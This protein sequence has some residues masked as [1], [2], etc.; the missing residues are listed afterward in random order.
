[1]FKTAEEEYKWAQTQ[2]KDCSKCKKSL[3][4]T[5]YKFNT[6]G[7][8]PFDRHG[9]RLLRPECGTCGKKV[10]AGKNKAI[11][12]A[13]E[14]GIPHKAPEGSSCAFCGTK[15]KLVFDHDHKTEEFRGWLCNS[16]NKALGALGD[17]VE[18]FVKI[19]NYFN[20]TEKRTLSVDTATGIIT[21]VI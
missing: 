6:S 4:R 16:H 11:A 7:A 5:Y 8:D 15:E 10:G 13:K 12:L 19:V 9:Y 2:T 17:N 3:P 1:V 21:I 20:K 18:E 14:K